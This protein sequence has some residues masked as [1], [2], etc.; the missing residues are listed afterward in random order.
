MSAASW[1]RQRDVDQELLLRSQHLAV[2][3]RMLKASLNRALDLVVSA[4][5]EA[6]PADHADASYEACIMLRAVGRALTLF[7]FAHFTLPD[8]TRFD[9]LDPPR[10]KIRVKRWIAFACEME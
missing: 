4:I 9:G 10:L 2:E 8:L 7:C 6:V 1:V 3:N 5:D